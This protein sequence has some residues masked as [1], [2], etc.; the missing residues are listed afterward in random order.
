MTRR[1]RIET[2]R[3]SVGVCGCDILTLRLLTEMLTIMA[4]QEDQIQHFRELV[5]DLRNPLRP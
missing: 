5:D 2:L 1:S 3:K 4:S